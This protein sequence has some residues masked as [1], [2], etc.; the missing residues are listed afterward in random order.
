MFS[1]SVNYEGKRHVVGSN[2]FNDK[3]MLSKF[4]SNLLMRISRQKKNIKCISTQ[5]NIKRNLAKSSGV[6]YV[7]LSGFN[8][9]HTEIRTQKSLAVLKLSIFEPDY[10]V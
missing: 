5:L 10:T 8:S 2:P 7:A 3:H 1:E 9:V 4:D 6:H